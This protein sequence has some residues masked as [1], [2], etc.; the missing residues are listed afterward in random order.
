MVKSCCYQK[1][2]GVCL[3]NPR[4][5]DAEVMKVFGDKKT[6]PLFGVHGA[7]LD[8]QVSIRLINSFT[9][10]SMKRTS[11]GDSWLYVEHS[12]ATSRG[13]VVADLA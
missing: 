10:L 7:V 9:S 4:H 11:L 8:Q 1:R 13:L 5:G 3:F 6:N 2:R 12:S